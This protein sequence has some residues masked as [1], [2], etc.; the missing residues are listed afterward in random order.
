M[1]ADISACIA[2]GEK[3]IVTREFDLRM[4]DVCSWLAVEKF[5]SDPLCANELE[6]KVKKEA[7]EEIMKKRDLAAAWKGRVYSRQR[8]YRPNKS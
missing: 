8:P 4:A 3:V 7:E 2:A 1:L 5:F 6:E